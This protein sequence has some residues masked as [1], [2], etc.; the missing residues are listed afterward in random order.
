LST[1]L[2]NRITALLLPLLA[3]VLAAVPLPAQQDRPAG[4]VRIY[5][6]SQEGNPLQGV[7]AQ[8]NGDLYTSDESGLLNFTIEPGEHE[9]QLSYE[10]R[11]IATVRAPVEDGKTTEVIVTEQEQRQQVSAAG[12]QAAAAG[13]D[14]QEERAEIDPDAPTGTITGQI[15]HIET[16]EPVANATVIFRNVALETTT[17]DEGRFS[18]NVPA[19]EYSFSVIHPDFSAQRMDQVE[20]S[21]DETTEISMEL[22]PSAIELDAVPVFATEEIRVQGGIASLIEE[23]RQSSQVVN[24]IGQEQLG[25]TGDADA[26]EALKRVTG[27]TVVDGRFVY[28]RGMGERYSISY[29]NDTRLPSPEIDRRVVP[30]DLFPTEVIESIQIQKSYSPDLLG[31]FGGG[32]VNIR[33]LGIPDDRYKRRLRT[34]I[35]ASVSY[36]QG[37]SLTERLVPDGGSLDWLGVDD[38]TRALPDAVADDYLQE[39]STITGGGFT[40]EELE[41]IGE[42][43]PDTLQPEEERLPLNY[44]SS[45][46]VRDKIE[47]GENRSFGFAT[48]LAYNNSWN[49]S[50]PVRN[51]YALAPGGSFNQD[52]TYESDLTSRDVDISALLDL[53]YNHNRRTD[54][55]TTSLLIRATD[56]VVD[57]YTGFFSDDSKYLQAT[58]QYWIEQTLFNQSIDSTIGLNFW[59]E[60]DLNIDYAFSIANRY[61]P[62]HRVITYE[63]QQSDDGSY[64]EETRILFDRPTLNYR[65]FND[66]RDIVNDAAVSMSVPIFWF[67][68]SPPDFLDFGVSGMLQNREADTRRFNYNY[69]QSDDALSEDPDDLFTDEYIGELLTFTE[70]TE[71]TDNYSADHLVLGGYFSADVLLFGDLRMDAGTRVEYS[72]QEVT[73]FDFFTGEELEPESLETVDLLPAVSFTLPT[74]D[75]SQLRFGGSRTVNRPG[76]RELSEAPKFGQPG[77]PV[78]RGNPELNRAVLYNADLRWEAY[79]AE[80]ESFSI[81]GFYKY[82]QDPIETLQL[83]GAADPRTYINV[84]SAFNVGAEVEWQLQF[85]YLSDILRN[86]M[87]GLNFDSLERERRWRRGLGV[88]SSF[89]RDLRTTGN[90]AY[91]YSRVD[92]GTSEGDITVN[93]GGDQ[94][95]VALTSTERPLQ[96]QS[97]WVLNTSLGYEN[98][99]SWSQERPVY[100]SVF[101]NYNVSGPRIVSLGSEGVPDTYE[102]PFHKLDLVVK[103][104]FNYVFTLSAKVENILNLPEEETLGQDGDTVNKSRRGR[105]FSL[106]VNF[107]L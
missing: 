43:F 54:V 36:N 51:T 25:R 73:T 40:E 10:G 104:Q 37:T 101:F 58:E 2:R 60:A 49:Y 28:V 4:E 41:K 42:S 80:R 20:V 72:L 71:A 92:Y 17:G 59:N 39:G 97:P 76:L 56:S 14:G 75:R 78:L 44:S 33:S 45:V 9:F 84:P 82:F 35:N 98:S 99:V 100:T 69:T 13:A 67:R 1:A 66:V 16:G 88:I 6:F 30:L 52:T 96:G 27:L 79:L 106:S 34:T 68:D 29:L 95:G 77:A 83:F 87:V 85:R 31:N 105:S 47:L 8:V 22:T 103:Q 61:E 89:F 7:R 53:A 48:S 55:Q 24:L 94:V 50:E 63:D 23:T 15:E 62:D 107:D 5:V 18:V 93:V 32:A 3:C 86:Y 65:L 91:I 102:Q 12:S 11:Q 81:G 38:G 90:F 70:N 64:D 57:Q 26:A 21:V 46:S 19:G 74:S